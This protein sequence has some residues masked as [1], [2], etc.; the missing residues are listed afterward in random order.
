LENFTPK[1]AMAYLPSYLFKMVFLVLKYK[2]HFFSYATVI[3][4]LAKAQID[5][6]TPIIT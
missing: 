4:V 1:N 3:D 2:A 6:M 5:Y